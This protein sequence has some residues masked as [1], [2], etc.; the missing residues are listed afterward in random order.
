MEEIFLPIKDFPMYEVSNK[1]NVKS[2]YKNKLMKPNLKYGYYQ[3]VF[4]KKN[5][6]KKQESRYIHRLVAEA[7]IPNPNEYECVNHKDENKLNNCVDNLEW[8]TK[9]YNNVYNDRA[10]KAGL[11]LRGRPTWNKGKTTSNE[12][13]RKISVSS[14]GHS[15]RGNQYVKRKI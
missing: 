12:T 1:G 4:Y 8:C 5:G 14:K 3:I 2:L 11:K 13:K 10:K 6:N 7:F 9:Q 15:F